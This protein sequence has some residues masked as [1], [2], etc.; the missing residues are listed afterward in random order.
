MRADV[1]AALHVNYCE[2]DHR[3]KTGSKMAVRPSGKTLPTRIL[4]PLT[5]TY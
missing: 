3:T 5:H 2:F 1:F 4:P